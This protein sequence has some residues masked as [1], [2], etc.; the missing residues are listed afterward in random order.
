MSTDL[1]PCI[2][3]IRLCCTDAPGSLRCA[4][5]AVAMQEAR[6]EV[7]YYYEVE[8]SGALRQ[9]EVHP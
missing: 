8:L 7:R 6:G 2:C 4:V 9:H 1:L 3:G 5:C